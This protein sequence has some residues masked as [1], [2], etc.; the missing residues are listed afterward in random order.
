M[1]AALTICRDIFVK[2]R[3]VA[4]TSTIWKPPWRLLRI[5]FWP[6][7]MIIGIAPRCA[8]AAPVVMLRAPGPSV[9]RQTPGRPVSR[10]WVAAMNAAA[11]S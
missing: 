3:M 8:Y 5:G 1:L 10:P 9:V 6:V 11:C 4:T 7:I 2:G